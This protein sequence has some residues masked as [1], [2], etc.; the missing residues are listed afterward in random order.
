MQGKVEP[1]IGRMFEEFHREEL[2]RTI[3][4]KENEQV[5][6]SKLLNRYKRNP[7]QG[8]SN[9]KEKYSKLEDNFKKFTASLLD[10]RNVNNYLRQSQNAPQPIQSDTSP[11]RKMAT[12]IQEV[13]DTQA[14]FSQGNIHQSITGQN[15][16]L[17]PPALAQRK[18]E[19]AAF[20][21]NGGQV[22]AG[23]GSG[24]VQMLINLVERLNNFIDTCF[25][26]LVVLCIS[27]QQEH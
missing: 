1:A 23:K 20:A 18:G 4:N 27:K 14:F 24:R 8:N 7:S 3:D 21:I 19:S 22:E 5:S 25:E 9:Y 13:Q 12:V 10:K 6:D 17:L 16:F 15:K 11:I 2:D 26:K